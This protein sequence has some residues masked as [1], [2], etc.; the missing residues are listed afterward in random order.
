MNRNVIYVAE[1]VLTEN[2]Y[3]DLSL[4]LLRNLRKCDIRYES[5]KFDKFE[6]SS[7]FSK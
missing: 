6:T 5:V 3:V 2:K 7:R 4:Q 1:I